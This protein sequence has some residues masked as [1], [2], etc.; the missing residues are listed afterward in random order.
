[1]VSVIFL[2]I[3]FYTVVKRRSEAAEEDAEEERLGPVTEQ[4]QGDADG[5]RGGRGWRGL[6]GQTQQ[7]A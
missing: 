5:Q 6:Q 4:L 7:E 3:S 1:M 2:F